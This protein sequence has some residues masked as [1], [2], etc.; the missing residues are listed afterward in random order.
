MVG[1]TAREGA[2]MITEIIMVIAVILAIG[3]IGEKDN[4][5]YYCYGFITCVIAVTILKGGIF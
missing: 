1:A 2:D 4:K 5:K 3:M